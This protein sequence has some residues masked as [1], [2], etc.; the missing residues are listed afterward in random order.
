MRQVSCY[1]CS[2]GAMGPKPRTSDLRQEWDDGLVE[3]AKAR[4]GLSPK[5]SKT[6]NP[7]KPTNSLQTSLKPRPGTPKKCKKLHSHMGVRGVQ[8]MDL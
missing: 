8:S 3:H 7:L 5:P 4:G 2:R 6:L 1:S